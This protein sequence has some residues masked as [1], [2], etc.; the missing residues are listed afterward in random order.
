MWR[1]RRHLRGRLRNFIILGILLHLQQILLILVINEL[2]VIDLRSLGVVGLLAVVR[3]GRRLVL[4]LQIHH[5][6]FL[7]CFLFFFLLLHLTHHLVLDL[8]LSHPL[9]LSPFIILHLLHFLILLL[10]SLLLFC[11][12]PLELFE[13]VFVVKEGV[14]K[15]F[16]EIFSSQKR[17]NSCFDYWHLQNVTYTR[18]TSVVLYQQGAYQ[19]MRVVWE[20]F[21]NSIEPCCHDPLSQL[22]QTS[23]IE[24]RLQCAHLIE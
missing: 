7:P 13:H 22:V 23:S 19:P 6:H 10:F 15:F 8:L 21:G 5:F 4:V 12:V 3:I 11:L 24:G 20:Y 18:P 16:F 2:V 17:W 14:W 9:L 1:L